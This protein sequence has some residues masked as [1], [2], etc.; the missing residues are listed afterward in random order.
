MNTNLENKIP[1]LNNPE[2]Y[3]LTHN[4]FDTYKVLIFTDLKKAQIYKMPNRNSHQQGIE[5]VTKFDYQHS[6]KPNG[7]DE[8]TRAGKENNAIFLFKIEDEKYKYVGEKI[9]TFKAIDD[10]EEFFSESKYNDVKYPSALSNE[11]IYYMLHQKY[12][13]IEE[14]DN[15]KMFDEY[16]YLNNKDSELKGYDDESMIEYGND[17]LNCKFID[18]KQI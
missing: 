12:I 6:F 16:Q 17:F 11:N 5:I 15:S 7:L 4:S 1:G 2:T 18:S 9:F 3:V 8:K 10:I 14:F 13:T